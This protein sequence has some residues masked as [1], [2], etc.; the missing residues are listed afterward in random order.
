[1]CGPIANPEQVPIDSGPSGVNTTVENYP[2]RM[3]TTEI[4]QKGCSLLMVQSVAVP[5]NPL[6]R[7]IEGQNLRIESASR[8]T[9]S[10]HITGYEATGASACSGNYDAVFTKTASS[11]G[12]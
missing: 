1:S 7:M 4:V 9:G 5:G 11:V 8:I 6:Q 12:P 3:V 2:N 10:V